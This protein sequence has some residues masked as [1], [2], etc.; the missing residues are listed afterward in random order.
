MYCIG[1]SRHTAN[2]YRLQV[3]GIVCTFTEYK[4]P[5]QRVVLV[6]GAVAASDIP[7]SILLTTSKQSASLM[8]QLQ[9]DTTTDCLIKSDC[10]YS[11]LYMLAICTLAF[12]LIPQTRAVDLLT[13]KALYTMQTVQCCL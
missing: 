2:I 12:A 3:I 9:Q 11:L 8:L 4:L 5:K 1:V 6:K 7:R 10:K 13:S